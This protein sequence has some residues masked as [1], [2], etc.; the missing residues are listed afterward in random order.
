MINKKNEVLKGSYFE[1]LSKED[2]SK[3]LNYPCLIYLHCNTGS[4]IEAL[5]LLEYLIPLNISLF[6]FD[7]TGCGKSDGE[8]ITLG[9]KEV[10]DVELFVNY[11]RNSKKISKIALWGRSMGA[12]TA[13][14][15]AQ[16]DPNISAL[17]IG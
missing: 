3:N 16:K 2:Q 15:Y 1:I 9:V 8:Y 6:C 5:P 14:K 13:L 4:R 12:V 11:L 17:I 10:E 7:F